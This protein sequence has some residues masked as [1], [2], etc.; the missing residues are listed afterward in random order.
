MDESCDGTPRPS[1]RFLFRIGWATSVAAH[2]TPAGN[3]WAATIDFPAA[4]Q[5]GTPLQ[6]ISHVKS[7]LSFE[8]SYQVGVIEFEG[9]LLGGRLIGVQR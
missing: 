7:H 2:F 5:L 9:M 6:K 4:E 1:R 8:L 3:D